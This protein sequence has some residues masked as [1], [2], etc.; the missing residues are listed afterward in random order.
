MNLLA[1]AAN[2]PGGASWALQPASPDG[3][4]DSKTTVNLRPLGH[5]VHCPKTL[6]GVTVHLDD[7]L[8]PALVCLARSY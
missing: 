5:T 2:P 3:Y 8:L 7:R 6:G 4:Y 1:E